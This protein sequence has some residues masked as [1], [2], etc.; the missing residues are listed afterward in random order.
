MR[1][2]IIDDEPSHVKGIMKYVGWDKIGFEAPIGTTSSIEALEQ[3]SRNKID[4]V[5]TDIRMPKI[6][7]LELI[8]KIH[9]INR[10]I[11]II[12][13][14]GYDEFLYAQEAIRLGV[15]AYLLKPE[16]LKE[17]LFECII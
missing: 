1:A 11:S 17:K 16:E 6:S 15:G 5:I 10:T 12:I 3:L 4:V 14:S 13:V 2:I 7:G 8:R 9:Q